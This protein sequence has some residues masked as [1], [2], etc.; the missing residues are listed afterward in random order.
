MKNLTMLL[1]AVLTA[2][3]TVP[4]LAMNEQA[5]QQ[6]LE[7]ARQASL[8][9]YAQEQLRRNMSGG[10]QAAQSSH[11]TATSSDAVQQRRQEI[12]EIARTTLERF[13][14]QVALAAQGGKFNQQECPACLN[15]N[16]A[17]D[18]DTKRLLSCG[19]WICWDCFREWCSRAPGGHF[20]CP[21][22]R[23]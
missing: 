22:C 15:G 6:Q 2:G 21:I 3:I 12:A 16:T 10:A 17:I 11:Q 14:K 7:R 13:K 20:T 9:T 1:S 23:K 8:T 19:H 5:E 18:Y 4:M